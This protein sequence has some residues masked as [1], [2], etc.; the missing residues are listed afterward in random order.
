MLF[1]LFFYANF[2]EGW[3]G[4]QIKSN[5]LELFCGNKWRMELLV[6]KLERIMQQGAIK[7]IS[8]NITNMC[9]IYVQQNAME[10]QQ[11]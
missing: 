1:L 3:M 8:L 9:K 10:P 4:M 2:M 11:P 5:F 7:I 6:R